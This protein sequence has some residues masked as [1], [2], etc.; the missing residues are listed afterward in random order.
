MENL[1]LLKK[2][3]KRAEGKID[4]F[5]RFSFKCENEKTHLKP[6]EKK[7]ILKVIILKAIYAWGN[8]RL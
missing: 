7:I 4:L 2:N 5:C 6:T 1:F 3:V 8:K